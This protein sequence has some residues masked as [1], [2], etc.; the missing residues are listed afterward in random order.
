MRN[1]K[2]LF[3]VFIMLMLSVPVFAEEEI[4]VIK[5]NLPL[6]KAEP[7]CKNICP[8]DFLEPK[9]FFDEDGHLM[10]PAERY[11]RGVGINCRVYTSTNQVRLQVFAR[12][13]WLTA[14]SKE[15]TYK[16]DSPKKELLSTETIAIKPTTT[17]ATRDL[18]TVETI[19]EETAIEEA[20]TTE[21]L[22]MEAAPVL[23]DGVFYMPI[24]FVSE[25]FEDDYTWDAAKNTAY[26]KYDRK[27][28]KN[29]GG[30]RRV[31]L[32]DVPV[33]AG[34][35]C[36]FEVDGYSCP[37]VSMYADMLKSDYPGQLVSMRE[38][39]L[40]VFD[41]TQ[42]NEV[43]AYIDLVEDRY[44]K[45]EQKAFYDKTKKRIIIVDAFHGEIHVDIMFKDL[46][47]IE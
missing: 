19:A 23:K 31:E 40:Q 47:L 26:V 41:E 46:P 6:L 25:I 43:M 35:F 14:G 17:T 16:C 10:V 37:F 28:T 45:L 15:A 8:I 44:F 38:T 22:M 13:L 20:P 18:E 34:G 7:N 27:K 39:L 11:S 4:Q 12:E 24:E 30:T 29:E 32:F 36:A 9:P 33:N 2:V 1:L 21:T 42:V 5:T 3:I